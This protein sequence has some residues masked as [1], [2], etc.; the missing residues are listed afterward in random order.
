MAALIGTVDHFVK[1]SSFAKYMERMKILYQLNNIPEATKKNLFITLS[2]PTIFDEICLIYPGVDI[3]TIDYD[4]M[5]NKLKER[6]DKTT[7]N[8]MNRHKFHSRIQGIEE[9]AENYVLALKLLASECGFGAHK[10][11]AIKDKIIFGLRDQELKQ[12]LLMRDGMS[13]EEVEELVVRSELAKLRAKELSCTEEG[14]RSVNSVK[15]RLGDVEQQR[16]EI[17]RSTR[18][19]SRD[20]GRRQR[21]RSRSM[22]RGRGALRSGFNRYNH[23]NGY[24]NEQRDNFRVLRDYREDN[25]HSS[26]ICNFCKKRGHVKR[27]CFKFM[28]Q[29]SVNFVEK[30]KEEVEYYDFKRLK[31]QESE[32]EESDYPCMMISAE[33]HFSEPCVVRVSVNGV[34]LKMEIDCGAAVTVIS[35]DHYRK[36]FSQVPVKKCNSRLVVVNGQR[37]GIFGKI[38]ADVVVDNNQ[39]R[40][41]L[42]ILDGPGKFVPLFGRDWMD[43]FYPQW[44]KAFVNVA[45]INSMDSCRQETKGYEADLALKEDRPIFRKAYDVP[46]K[47]REKVTQH[48]DSLEKQNVISPIQVSEWASPVVIVL[49]KDNDIRMVLDCKVS[50]NK[51]IIPTTYPLPLAQDIF[52]SLSGCKWFCCLDLAGAYTQLKLSERSK[53]FVV[54]NT[55]KGLYVY[56]RLPQGA[57]SSASIFQRVMDSILIGL[58]YVC[59]Y[60]DDVLIAGRTLK[61][62]KNNLYLVLQR[63]QDA[64]V[65]VNL[66]KCKLFVQSLPYLGHLITDEG[67]L[68]SPEKLL[69]V[70]EAKV[71]KDV[72]ELKAFLGLINY[73][74]RFVPHLSVK[75]SCLYALLK[76]GARY[77]WDERCQTAFQESKTALINAN[78]LEFY[79]PNKPIIVISDACNYGLGGVLAHLVDGKEKPVSFVSFSLNAAQKAYPILHL[80]A[81]ALLCTVKKFHKFLFGQKFTIYTDHKPLLGIFGKEGKH[82]LCVTRL[83]RYAMNMSIYNFEIHYRPS[84]Q[85]GNADFCSRFPLEQSV[86]S[87]IDNGQI[88]SINFFS[89]FPLDFSQIAKESVSD[90]F[91]SKI[92]LY[93]AN[94]WP[95]RIEKGWQQ[96]YSVRNELEIADGCIL[97]QDRVMIPLSLRLPMLKLLHA[98]HSGIVRMKQ[99]ARRSLF[100]FGL[101]ADI[102]N[103]VKLCQACLKTA[104]VPKPESN[105]SWML[106]T[107]PFSRIHADFFY[108]DSKTYLLVVDSHTKWLEIELMKYGTDAGK[109]IKKFTAIFARFGLPDVLVTDGGPPFNSSQFTTFMERQGIKVMKSPPYNPSSNGQAE[110]MVRVA[111]DVFK[112]FLLEPETRS[113][114]TEDRI[115]YFL[116]NYRNTCN[117]DDKFPSEKMLSFKPKTLIDLV[118]PKRQY[119]HYLEPL[120]EK[121]KVF[122]DTCSTP[123]Q[124]PFLMLTLGDKVLYKNNNKH[125][126]ER[127]IVA[128]Y[129]KRVSPSVFRISFDR[130]VINAHRDQLKLIRPPVTS[131]RFQITVP[132]KQCSKRQRSDSLSGEEDF[133]GFP[134]V[135]LVPENSGSDG[136]RFKIARRSPIRT[137]SHTRASKTN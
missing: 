82:Q 122:V 105:S 111:K 37:L 22:E 24:V 16:S 83:Q 49:K 10:D 90:S 97:Y 76:K 127:W 107:R 42:I 71:P 121:E 38:E 78:I 69:T 13:L 6:L 70:Q 80:E 102:E 108:F 27:N 45:N 113:L 133:H 66:K 103:F 72:S 36:H 60:L 51:C 61:E 26:V 28:N 57:S 84:S 68:P 53:K 12:K 132:S 56:N 75:L 19:F 25:V 39:K 81:L 93:I 85:M 95:H 55:I 23:R 116:M 110:R 30:E 91:L 47:L 128:K 104:V 73:Y 86:P 8:M 58:E 89:D 77:I 100:W 94:G 130:H 96:V 65:K 2:G 18:Q 20:Y 114:D 17:G 59:C 34:Q 29:R 123:S 32:D 63:L 115:T 134:D 46:F 7:P 41:N 9:P 136:R 21:S 3:M 126:I 131:A 54:I 67:I 119:K 125:S 87:H 33:E 99:L 88:N 43:L 14:P 129:V 50:I 11:E 92:A 106:T 117:S 5:I 124:D 98:N 74:G 35:R 31:L 44:R 109:V 64:N 135:P 62:C 48:L 120:P 101:N 79:D 4:E 118:H 1:G 15:Y 52:A 137:R 40:A 112:K